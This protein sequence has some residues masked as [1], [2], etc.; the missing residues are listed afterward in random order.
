MTTPA[1]GDS[2][3][4][5]D[6]CT[7]TVEG[8]MCGRPATVHIVWPGYYNANACDEHRPVGYN[9][10]EMHPHTAACADPGALWQPG[11]HTCELPRSTE[12]FVTGIALI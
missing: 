9:V 12:D 5:V 11:K 4:Y 8:G 10:I 6:Y 7:R 1:L 2:N 3:Y